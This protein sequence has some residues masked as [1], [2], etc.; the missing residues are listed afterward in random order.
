V[1]G[2]AVAGLVNAAAEAPAWDRTLWQV[3][4]YGFGLLVAL[5]WLTLQYGASAAPT[6]GVRLFALRLILPAHFLTTAAIVVIAAG[7]GGLAEPEDD[8]VPAATRWV[9]CAGAAC[10]S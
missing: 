6:Y 1:L 4:L 9:L 5:W 7:L 2:E 3:G 8:A 10:T